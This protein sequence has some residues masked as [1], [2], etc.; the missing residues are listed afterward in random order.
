MFA[1][2]YNFTPKTPGW[3]SANASQTTVSSR[4]TFMEVVSGKKKRRKAKNS[5]KHSESPL[6]KRCSLYFFTFSLLDKR[7]TSRNEGMM[8]WMASWT[9]RG[10][11]EQ[12]QQALRYNNDMSTRSAL[13]CFI[14]P[15]LF[16]V[17]VCCC[18]FSHFLVTIFPWKRQTINSL[19]SC[20]SSL[21]NCYCKIS[22][23]TFS[24]VFNPLRPK[25]RMLI[26]RTVIN[27][28]PKEN[29]RRICLLIKSFIS[30]WSFSLFSW[31]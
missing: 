7:L 14:I 6:S 23:E 8:N 28:F 31:P 24:R 17:V 22:K 27:T 21:S 5:F 30:W 1:L 20:H 18:W 11:W 2:T 12:M 16:F 10:S 13:S 3:I 29:T 19:T 9:R 25:I 15:K 26:L 4:T